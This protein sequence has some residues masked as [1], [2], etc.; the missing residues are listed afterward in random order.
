M[1]KIFAIKDKKSEFYVQIEVTKNI[2]KFLS[3]LAFKL[4]DEN[5]MIDDLYQI[6][7]DKKEFDDYFSFKKHNIYLVVVMTQERAHIIILGLDN[8]KKIKDFVLENYSLEFE[9]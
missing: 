5:W 7:W 1:K 6:L 8:N 4:F 3:D 2:W 9:E